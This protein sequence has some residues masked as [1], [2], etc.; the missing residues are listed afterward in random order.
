[1]KISK[2]IRPGFTLIELLA[3]IAIVAVMAALLLSVVGNIIWKENIGRAISERDQLETAI[4]AY[5]SKYGSYPPSNANVLN[6]ITNQLYYELMGTTNAGNDFTTLDDA[7]MISALNVQSY[8]GVQAFMN[9]NKSKS[10]ADDFIPAKTFLS[11]L[12]PGE[13][14]S[15]GD[16]SIIVTAANSDPGYE[17]APGF[18]SLTGRPANPWCYRYPGTNNPASYDLWVNVYVGGKMNLVCNW[19]KDVQTH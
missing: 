16:C 18:S 9:C 17:P 11:G 15:N 4:E 13:I 3:V 2:N 12:K 19:A 6:S 7:S 1:M 10:A 8:F 5:K 14:A